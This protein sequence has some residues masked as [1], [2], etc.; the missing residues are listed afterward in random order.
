[1]TSIAALSVLPIGDQRKVADL[2]R[3][4]PECFPQFSGSSSQRVCAHCF[5]DAD[6]ID[7]IESYDEQTDCDFCGKDDAPTAPFGEI[8]EHIKAR[9]EAFYGKAAEQ[10]PFESREGGYQGDWSDT[11]D[12]LVEDVGLGLPR[13]DS[14]ALLE[15]LVDEIGE[16]AWCE[17]DWLSLE[18]DESWRSS[19]EAFCEVVKHDR[20]FF[21]HDVGGRDLHPDDR[22]PARFFHELGALIDAQDLV[23]TVDPGLQLF[24]ARVRDPG[25]QFVSAADL[26]PPPANCALQSNR[27]NPPG[28]PMFYGAELAELATAETRGKQVSIGQFESTRSIRILDLAHL[29]PVPGF[30]SEA[31]RTELFAIA[32]MTQFSDLIIQP[33]DRDDRTQLDY[34]PTQVFTEFLRDYEFEGGKIDGIKYR[35]ATGEVGCNTV[36]FATPDNVEDGS[37][38]PQW[39]APPSRWLRLMD[40]QHVDVPAES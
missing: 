21:F 31:H 28:I 38:D 14:G 24:R 20:R 10:L 39:G 32:F 25:Q 40:V 7:R 37:P 27:M 2:S 8:A 13:D 34:I 17:Y 22:S 29:P 15:A 19:W 26:G 6:L 16:N 35:S 30:F 3:I 1:M 33:V 12:L 23:Q 11:H 5:E 36:L 4:D 9:L 18:P